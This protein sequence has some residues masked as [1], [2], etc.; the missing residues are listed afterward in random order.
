MV[1]WGIGRN[2]IN[3]NVHWRKLG[4][5]SSW[6]A[7]VLSEEKEKFSLF[8]VGDKAGNTFLWWRCLLPLLLFGVI[9]DA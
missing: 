4:V 2:C 3:Q 1:K 5:H 9:D 7:S 6:W 8:L